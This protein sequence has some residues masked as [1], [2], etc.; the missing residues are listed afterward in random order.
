MELNILLLLV[1]GIAFLGMVSLPPLLKKLPVSVPLIYIIVGIGIFLLPFDYPEFL[2]VSQ[3]KHGLLL[4]Y[5]TELIVI[6]SLF[7]AGV[8]MDRDLSRENLSGGLRLVLLTM[9]LS[10]IA[11][12]L[13]GVYGL[14]LSIPTA[15]LLGAVLIP[16]DPVLAGHIQV[17]P[18]GSRDESEVRH[19]LTLEAGLNDGL[20]FPFVYLALAVVA[21]DEPW[22]AVAEWALWDLGYKVIVGGAMGLLLGYLLSRLFFL[23][24]SK[25]PDVEFRGG[26]YVISAVLLSYA[27]TEV[28]GGYGFLAAFVA[29]YVGRRF[30]K[31]SKHHLRT[32]IYLEQIEQVILTLLLLLLGELVASNMDAI[33]QPVCI[34]VALALLLV[35]RP[36][37]GRLSL[38]GTHIKNSE[39]WALS[40]LGVRGIG[41]LYYLAYAHNRADF[42]GIEWVWGIVITT[43]VLSI[44]IHG[45]TAK[46][47]LRW[48]G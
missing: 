29:G 10:M 46:P 2:P 11:L 5:L 20:A 27:V 40:F 38:I 18:P 16:T 4:E 34:V 6:I 48:L 1:F 13:I 39:K 8:R 14:A 26:I 43:V 32:S 23:I 44:L 36:L 37:L 30:N 35:I 7:A 41:S 19:S 21:V 33:F 31:A 45:I 15:I 9:P 25:T 28:V 42:E 3:P 17:G 12:A 22:A 24:A 47:L